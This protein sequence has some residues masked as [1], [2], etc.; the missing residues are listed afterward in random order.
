MPEIFWDI[1]GIPATTDTSKIRKAYS[2]LVKEHGPEDDEE[3][4]KK[5]NGAYKAACKFAANFERLG[6]SDEQI[7]ITDKRPDGSFGVKFLDND[8]K[9]L[10]PT[11]PSTLP[12]LDPRFAGNKASEPQYV[13]DREFDFESIDSS[14]IKDYSFEE[15]SERAGMISFATGFAV[16]DSPKTRKI[17]KFLDDNKIILDLSKRV[18]PG[19]EKDGRGNGLRIAKLIM[20]SEFIDQKVIW[21]FFFTSPLVISLRID[22]H[23]YIRLEDLINEKCFPVETLFAIANGSGMRPFIVNTGAK[24]NEKP[25]YA[26]DLR[27]RVPFRYEEG[28]YP[29]L[30][31]LMKKE[32]PEE[33]KK[34]A[35]FLSKVSIN[36][37]GML[38]PFFH[39]NIKDSVGEAAYAFNYIT[40]SPDCKD[41]LDNRLLWK[42]YFKGNLVNPI[43]RNYDLHMAIKT[44]TM[45]VKLP[46]K[47][48]KTIKKEMS[49]RVPAYIVGK[50]EDRKWCYLFF[51]KPEEYRGCYTGHYLERPVIIGE[52]GNDLS[53]R[54]A[55]MIA[56]VIL[57]FA[58]MMGSYLL[59]YD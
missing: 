30:D 23:F 54:F 43:M 53:I 42:L 15:V 33:Y 55:I 6:V 32:K 58:I 47:V 8:G 40:T 35:D 31:K 39:P 24:V 50:K 49:F 57:F 56:V 38:M 21:Q 20:D 11:P 51:L 45:K 48:L 4:F 5:I 17:K 3:G 13:E 19:E 25:K 44:Q 28:K 10:Y 29:E 46:L 37:Y 2:K 14:V 12:E 16:P 36:L 18:M 1:L 22:L 34:L 7:V 26:I 59:L 27:S 52:H 9:P 41:M